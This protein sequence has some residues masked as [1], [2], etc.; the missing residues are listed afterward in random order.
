MFWIQLD[1]QVTDDDDDDVMVYH[2]FFKWKQQFVNYGRV[3]ERCSVKGH[4][5]NS[6]ACIMPEFT[7]Y[8]RMFI[9]V[10]STNITAPSNNKTQ[11]DA[12]QKAH[13]ASWRFGCNSPDVCCR[14]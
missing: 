10:L 4:L 2:V 11:L 3:T 1:E 14:R 9:S 12:V 6:F 8:E 13:D 7:G 5:Q